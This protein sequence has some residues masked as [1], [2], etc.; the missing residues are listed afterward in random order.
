MI[1][2]N[3]YFPRVGS[4]Y[5]WEG[6]REASGYREESIFVQVMVKQ[7]LIFSNKQAIIN[8]S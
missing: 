4:V 5:K 2:Y 1:F 7:G 8:V 6:I 3:G